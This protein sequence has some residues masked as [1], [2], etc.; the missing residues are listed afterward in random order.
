[1]GSKPK[2]TR[3]SAAEKMEAKVAAQKAE[4]FAQNYAPLNVAELKDSLSDDISNL[5]RGRGNADV[6]QG[7]TST[8]TYAATQNAGD[9]VADLTGAYQ[10][11]LGGA[12][13]GALDIQNKRGSAAVG[14][15]QGQSAATAQASSLLTNIGTNRALDKAKNKQLLRQAKIDAVMKVAGAAGDKKFGA[16]PGEKPTAWDKMREGIEKYK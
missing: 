1:M 9:V 5:A 15:A 10:S 13:S 7:L 12:T 6:M 14:S 11:T 3:A 4:F 8:P 2:K 16:K